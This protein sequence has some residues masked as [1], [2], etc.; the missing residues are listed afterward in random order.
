MISS[1]QVIFSNQHGAQCLEWLSGK[2]G[3]AGVHCSPSEWRGYATVVPQLLIPTTPVSLT[4]QVE[5][6]PA[7]VPEEIAELARDTQAVLPEALQR[8]LSKCDTRLGIMSTSPAPPIETENAV[9]IVAQTNLDPEQPEVERLLLVLANITDGF[10]VDC[11]NGR[12][13]APG[14]GEWVPL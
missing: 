6:D 4:I 12:L 13:L 3:E 9:A 2:L 5:N 7:Y 11:V 10:V 14:G 1:A 8:R